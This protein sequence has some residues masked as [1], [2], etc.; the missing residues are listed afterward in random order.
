MPPTPYV[1]DLAAGQE[2]KDILDILNAPGQLGR[3]YILA[4]DVPREDQ[5]KGTETKS[6]DTVMLEAAEIVQR[7]RVL[8]R[9]NLFDP[10]EA[11][12][13]YCLTR[14]PEN[15]TGPV[16]AAVGEPPSGSTLIASVRLLAGTVS[17]C[18]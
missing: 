3:P 17:G 5:V 2:Q 12:R 14:A 4:K 8:R 9:E 16:G 13:A 15:T 18:S 11:V 7:E 10:A 1:D 6:G